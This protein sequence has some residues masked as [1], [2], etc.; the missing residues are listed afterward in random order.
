MKNQKYQKDITQL[1]EKMIKY[2][3]VTVL[4]FDEA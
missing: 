3:R 1:K 4:G 2:S